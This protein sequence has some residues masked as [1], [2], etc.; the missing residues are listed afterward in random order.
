MAE[1]KTAENLTKPSVLRCVICDGEPAVRN[2]SFMSTCCE[3]Y[4]VCYQCLERKQGKL[5]CKE[6][7]GIITPYRVR[8]QFI[9]SIVNE[10]QS[11]ASTM[12]K[13]KENLVEKEETGNSILSRIYEVVSTPPG[14]KVRQMNHI[15]QSIMKDF[16]HSKMCKPYQ[17]MGYMCDLLVKYRKNQ[18]ITITIHDILAFLCVFCGHSSINGVKLPNGETRGLNKH[19]MYDCANEC[20][21][22]FLDRR[23]LQFT[24]G[25]CECGVVVMKQLGIKPATEEENEWRRN[26]FL[27]RGGEGLKRV[28]TDN[29]APTFARL[30]IYKPQLLIWYIMSEGDRLIRDIMC[31]S[32]R[33]R[34]E[35]VL[36]LMSNLNG[37]FGQNDPIR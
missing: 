11:R 16:K 20:C 28:I 26:L 5:E 37:E 10:T 13:G 24:G 6:C 7:N 34:D 19:T 15:I 9:R 2:D 25:Q 35:K 12:E 36:S 33:E 3:T 31:L 23:F 22:M 14:V 1:G 27:G 30:K 29:L 4:I 21:G 18:G 32:H 8:A 17:N